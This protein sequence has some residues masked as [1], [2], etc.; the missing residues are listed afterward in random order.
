MRI[1]KKSLLSLV[2]CLAFCFAAAVPGIWFKPD[3]WFANLQKPPWMP[4]DAVFGPVW[5][6]LYFM[7]A[8]SLWRVWSKT[9]WSVPT[10]WFVTQWAFNLAWSYIFF[11]LHEPIWALL[12]ILALWVSLSI[13]IWQFRR[14]DVRATV[15]LLPYWLWVSFTTCLNFYIVKLNSMN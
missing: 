1:T 9:G 11:G 15:L 3:A 10:K 6:L 13:T 7:M 4:P 2:V 14:V 12:N 8:F 5:T